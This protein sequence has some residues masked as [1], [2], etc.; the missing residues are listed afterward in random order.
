MEKLRK[1]GSALRQQQQPRKGNLRGMIDETL[2]GVDV[3]VSGRRRTSGG[4]SGNRRTSRTQAARLRSALLDTARY[5]PAGN[6][7]SYS[8]RGRWVGLGDALQMRRR[9]C[10]SAI[11]IGQIA[12]DCHTRATAGDR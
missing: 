2:A 3:A 4:T 1:V 12:W 6:S 10:S 9:I 7:R 11:R 8:R 5:A